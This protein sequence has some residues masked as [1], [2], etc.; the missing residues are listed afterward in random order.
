MALSWL[1]LRSCLL[2]WV[3]GRHRKEGT[4]HNITP[5]IAEYMGPLQRRQ[6]DEGDDADKNADHPEQMK[7]REQ[8]ISSIS[9]FS[10]M[11][12][13]YTFGSKACRVTRIT[14]HSTRRPVPRNKLPSMKENTAHGTTMAGMPISGIRST[15][16]PIIAIV[17]AY[18]TPR[19]S[20]PT[21]RRV[22]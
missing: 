13:P 12:E 16:P 8:K 17:K 15:M 7:S 22:R 21:K 4:G 5:D 19:T 2:I 18:S 9:G 20:S 11:L 10:P 3:Q 6:D 1:S 14:G